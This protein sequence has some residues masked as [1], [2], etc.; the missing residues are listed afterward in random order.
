MNSLTQQSIQSFLGRSLSRTALF[1]SYGSTAIILATASVTSANSNLQAIVFRADPTERSDSTYPVWGIDTSRVSFMDAAK[2]RELLTPLL[3][4]TIELDMLN[5]IKEGVLGYYRGA[6]HPFVDVGIP[7][8]DVTDGIV[9]VIVS[10]F[11]LNKITIEGNEWFSDRQILRRSGLE[12]GEVI[13]NADLERRMTQLNANPFIKVAPEFKPGEAPATT[14]VVL[15]AKDQFPVRLT[16]G[17]DNSGGPTT[18][19]DRWNL[20]AT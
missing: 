12:V 7:P 8:Q 10:E 20:G 15:R 13:D 18:G 4:R 6:G 19:W 3:G 9:D 14:E 1:F 11:R 2:I 17:Y 5:K 16:A